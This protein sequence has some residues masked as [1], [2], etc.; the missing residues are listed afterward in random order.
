MWGA[1]ISCAREIYALPAK[2]AEKRLIMVGHVVWLIHV[3]FVFSI[4]THFIH[5]NRYIQ[6]IKQAYFV[7]SLSLYLSASIF[8]SC[9]SEYS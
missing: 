8:T 1:M 4:N 2:L 6:S 5:F 3:V 9:I 7:F